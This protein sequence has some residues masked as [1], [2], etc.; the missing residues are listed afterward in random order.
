M[1]SQKIINLL[2]NESS[3]LPKFATKKWYII[4]DQNGGNNRYGNGE[5]GT[6]IKYET[7]VIKPNL[8]DYFDAYILVKGT[9]ANKPDNSIVGFKNCVPFRKCDV[10]INDEYIE[11][12]KDLDVIMPMYNFLEYSDSYSDST[13]TLYQ[14]KRDEPPDNNGNVANNT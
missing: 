2:H 12:A 11:K 7:K 14:F 13:G 10:T 4:N 5:N 1:E 9:I 8:C 6:T 3:D